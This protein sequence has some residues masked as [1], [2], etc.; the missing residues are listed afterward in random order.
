[1]GRSEP[2]SSRASCLT[3]T[4]S[5]CPRRRDGWAEARWGSPM[6]MPL[7]LLDASAS[8]S[9]RDA[10]TAGQREGPRKTE[11]EVPS[12][13]TPA[14]PTKRRQGCCKRSRRSKFHVPPNH[15]RQGAPTTNKTRSRHWPTPCTPRISQTLLAFARPPWHPSW[16]RKKKKPEEGRS[17]GLLVVDDVEKNARPDASQSRE[18][19]LHFPALHARLLYGSLLFP[20]SPM[21]SACLGIAHCLPLPTTACGPLGKVGTTAVNLESCAR[22]QVGDRDR[23]CRIQALP[24]FSTDTDTP[25]R[26]QQCAA[27]RAKDPS[28]TDESHIARS[29]QMVAG[30]RVQACWGGEGGGSS[31]DS[32][33]F[34]MFLFL[35]SSFVAVPWGAFSPPGQPAEC[36]EN[37]VRTGMIVLLA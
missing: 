16:R 8:I 37:P 34:L 23:A 24:H 36:P 2:A 6:V 9:M 18:P 15:S 27:G 32:P 25:A 28:M 35:S 19:Q 29:K 31:N 3:N 5:R 26:D 17:V 7:L 22:H 12:T 20:F 30:S 1:M 4:G 33:R 21:C 11:F 10:C 14:W 13:S